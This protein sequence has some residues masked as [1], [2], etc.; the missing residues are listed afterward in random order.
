MGSKKKCSVFLLKYCF[1][2]DERKYFLATAK[3]SFF[4]PTG[5]FTH[6]IGDGLLIFSPLAT[7]YT[8]V[9]KLIPQLAEIED[10]CKNS[11]LK[12]NG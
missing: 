10:N 8:M 7:L 3:S 4:R 12:S 1:P 6:L 5:Y 11:I 2:A 9:K